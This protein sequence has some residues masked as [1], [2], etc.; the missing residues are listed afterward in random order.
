VVQQ[1]LTTS[2][3]PATAVSPATQNTTTTTTQRAQGRPL[4]QEN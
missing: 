1:S 4:H 3:W 2:T